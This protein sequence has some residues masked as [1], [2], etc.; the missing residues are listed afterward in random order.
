MSKDSA[1]SLIETCV[2]LLGL[3]CNGRHL[4]MKKKLLE[5]PEVRLE[6]VVPE[7]EVHQPGVGQGGARL[8]HRPQGSR[9]AV[10]QCRSLRRRLAFLSDIS[11]RQDRVS[12]EIPDEEPSRCQLE[13]A[14][15][16][17]VPS[18]I[19]YCSAPLQ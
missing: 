3:P 15:W 9:V 7:H 6:P 12:H 4:S 17:K 11:V 16:L 10:L 19:E 14:S 2:E 13:P 18:A 5:H 1:L 8:D